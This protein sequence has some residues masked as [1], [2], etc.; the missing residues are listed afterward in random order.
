MSI[1]FFL[2]GLKGALVMG[3]LSI[4]ANSVIFDHDGELSSKEIFN[5]V[6]LLIGAALGG[7]AGFML[8]PGSSLAT[9]IGIIVGVG[10]SLRFM[11]GLDKTKEEVANGN[12]HRPENIVNTEKD[13]NKIPEFFNEL[14]EKIGIKTQEISDNIGF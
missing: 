12:F 10:I 7:I 2:G 14:K 9:G 13:L 4:I 1:G 5:S 6:L 11:Q 3:A 8:A